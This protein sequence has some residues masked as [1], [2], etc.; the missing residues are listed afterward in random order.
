MQYPKMLYK[1]PGNIEL[2]DGKYSLKTVKDEDEESVAM[3][4]GWSLTTVEAKHG[5]SNRA[6]ED[7]G[8]Y[9]ADDPETPENEAFEGGKSERDILKE[10]A[11]G[12]GIEYPK[13]IKTKKLKELIS[14][15]VD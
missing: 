10:K 15:A 4:D 9:K 5:N 3:D 14:N 1:Y 13:N 2:Q 12:L 6:R 11:D 7:N 8:T